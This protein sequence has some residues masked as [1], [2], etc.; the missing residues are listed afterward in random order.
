MS[1]LSWLPQGHRP[2]IH[3]TIPLKRR[4][5]RSSGAPRSGAQA[6]VGNVENGNSKSIIHLTI[7]VSVTSHYFTGKQICQALIHEIPANAVKRPWRRSNSHRPP[8]PIARG[9][10]EAT[11]PG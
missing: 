1:W 9:E 11:L 5:A 8:V 7:A 6:I 3:S 10:G 4:S 2:K